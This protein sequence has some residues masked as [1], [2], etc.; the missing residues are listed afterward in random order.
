MT[1]FVVCV[2]TPSFITEF[3]NLEG[4]LLQS[5][6]IQA[7]IIKDTSLNWALRNINKLLTLNTAYTQFE[8]HLILMSGSDRGQFFHKKAFYKKVA[9]RTKK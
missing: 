8:G 9:L 1:N 4:L 7:D 6:K 5:L 3:K 2:S